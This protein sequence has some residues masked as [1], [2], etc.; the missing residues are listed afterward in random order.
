M[1]ITS[2]FIIQKQCICNSSTHNKGDSFSSSVMCTIFLSA[3]IGARG[4]QRFSLLFC[5]EGNHEL[6]ERKT[7]TRCGMSQPHLFQSMHLWKLNVTTAVSEC[8]N[9]QARKRSRAKE[10]KTHRFFPLKLVCQP[11]ESEIIIAEVLKLS[12][13]CIYST[14][15]DSISSVAMMSYCFQFCM[16]AHFSSRNAAN[17]SKITTLSCYGL[18]F[19]QKQKIKKDSQID[20]QSSQCVHKKSSHNW[21]NCPI[22]WFLPAFQFHF[23][24]FR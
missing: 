7:R 19:V 15:T 24:K 6:E 20:H 8:V 18:Q 12:V 17:Y 11:I 4:A 2:K 22:G 9:E 14:C 1:R 3:L 16:N 5:S 13:G 23:Q 21:Y 10:W